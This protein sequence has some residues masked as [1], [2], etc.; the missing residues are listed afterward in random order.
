MARIDWDAIKRDYRTAR[1]T[2]PELAE[3]H[4]VSR[5]AICR[6]RKKDG[7]NSD[8]WPMD[9]TEAI[10]QAT[11]AAL[12]TSLITEDHRKVTDTVLA[13][14]EVNKQVLLGH[15]G[16][17]TDLA[18][19]ME[20]ARLSV[21]T[22]GAAVGNIQQAATFVQAVGGLASATKILIDKERETY[23][24]NEAPAEVPKPGTEVVHRVAIDFTDIVARAEAAGE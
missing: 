14:A 7:E 2:D 17:L 21:I 8:P 1:Y 22:H 19:A 16:W 3:K 15:R 6:K 11:D 9:L 4:N 20:A 12:V 18:D 5:E 24:L 10:K 23:K 13:M